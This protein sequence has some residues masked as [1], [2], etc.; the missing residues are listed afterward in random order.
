MRRNGIKYVRLEGWS[1]QGWVFAVIIVIL[2]IAAGWFVIPKYITSTP[3]VTTF[4][5]ATYRWVY[6]ETPNLTTFTGNG[7]DG[8]WDTWEPLTSE[9]SGEYY[10]CNYAMRTGAAGAVWEVKDAYGRTNYT[11]AAA[12]MDEPI[13]KVQGFYNE[14]TGDVVYQAYYGSAWHELAKRTTDNEFYEEAIRWKI[15]L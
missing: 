1:D 11:L 8:D 3:R 13:V 15:P 2:I 12:A 9:S 5:D 7:S 10:Y 4:T 14:T 6:Q